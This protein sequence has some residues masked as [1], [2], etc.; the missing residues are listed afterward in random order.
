MYIF[1]GR[2]LPNFVDNVTNDCK[3]GY[4]LCMY[5]ITKTDNVTSRQTSVLG[6]IDGMDFKNNQLMFPHSQTDKI[7]V[8]TLQC[9]PDTDESVLYAPLSIERDQVVS[10]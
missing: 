1:S 8:V 4:S 2:S 6:K 5:S 9:T 7:A 10:I 3:E